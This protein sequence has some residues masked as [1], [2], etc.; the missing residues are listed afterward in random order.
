MSDASELWTIPEKW[1]WDETNPDFAELVRVSEAQQK[2]WAEKFNQPFATKTSRDIEMGRAVII[3]HSHGNPVEVAEAWAILGRYDLAVELDPRPATGYAEI[4]RAI[5][6][7]TE[8]CGHGVG[9]RI[10]G[11]HP[12]YR[13]KEV[14]N[15]L[16]GS[17]SN[18]LR[19]SECGHR[20][21]GP[22]PKHLVKQEEKRAE[23]KRL[24][25]GGMNPHTA[26]AQVNG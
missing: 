12:Q 1:R 26:L 10:K 18:V 17:W 19:C 6:E 9:P 16:T 25:D 4:W 5:T 13:E 20:Q 22:L 2:K 15:V 14:W 24:V 7:P 8:W 21:V 11:Q 3:A 23:F